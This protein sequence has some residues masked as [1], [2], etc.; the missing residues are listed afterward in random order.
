[1][2]NSVRRS[3]IMF[4]HKSRDQ[5][6]QI[7]KIQHGGRPPFK[8]MIFFAISQDGNHP[9]SWKF[10]V[11]MQILVPIT[12]TS[13]NIKILQIQYG[14]RPPYWKSFFGYISTTCCPINAK[15]GTKKQNHVRHRSRDQHA[16]FRKFKIADNRHLKMVESLYLSRQS[17]VFQWSLVCQMQI[18]VLTLVTWQ[19]INILRFQNGG[20]PPYW[21]R[22]WLYLNDH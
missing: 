9:I 5:K 16:K 3:T 2:R 11:Q 12:A 20:W 14:S 1:M 8:K 4:R 21:N 22:F 17:S 19:S 15:F 7:S 6:Y 18:L 10:G 13:Q